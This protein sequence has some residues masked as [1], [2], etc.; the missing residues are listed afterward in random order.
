MRWP[1]DRAAGVEYGEGADRAA[2]QHGR[3]G[4][5]VDG[6]DVLAVRDAAR[7]A[8]E[9]A[10]T[11][12]RPRLL[13]TVSYRLRGHSVV[14]PARYRTPRTRPSYGR[15]STSPSISTTVQPFTTS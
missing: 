2:V 9:Q 1:G 3:A 15:A 5:R 7:M 8:L 11:E 14:A 12:H 4:T 13:E 10:R 6:G